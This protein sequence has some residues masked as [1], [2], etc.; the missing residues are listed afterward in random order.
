MRRAKK[1]PKQRQPSAK[2]GKVPLTYYRSGGPTSSSPFEKAAPA[3]RPKLKKISLSAINLALLAIILFGL[4]YIS[5]V[6]SSPKLSLNSQVYH[7]AGV[8]RAV[9]ADRLLSL[10]NHNKISFSE[11]A[12]IQAL[13]LRFPEIASATL[14]LPIFSQTPNIRLYISPPALFLNNQGTTYVV[15]QQGRAVARANELPQIKDL[16]TI[17][18]SSGFSASKGSA[19]LSA[20]GVSFAQAL[21]AHC[22]QAKIPVKSL[23]LPA[24]PG[25]LD[26]RTTDKD[27]YTKFFLAGNQAQQIGQFLAS[28]HQFET[29]GPQPAEYL[30]VRVP[31]KIFYK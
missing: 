15:D 16:P 18:D 9:A 26:L 11:Q 22:Q 5:L 17:S 13:Q 12:V 19:A 21:I 3:P 23:T 30:D 20:Q 8:Y 4:F 24:K 14:E 1:Q 6:K 29:G 7:P 28:R 2:G 31:G 10:K 25:E 27:Y